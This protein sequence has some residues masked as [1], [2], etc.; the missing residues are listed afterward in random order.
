MS[1][2]SNSILTF[3]GGA[4]TGLILGFFFALGFFVTKSANSNGNTEI[5]ENK[6]LKLFDSPKQVINAKTFKVLQYCLTEAHWQHPT[7]SIQEKVCLNMERLYCF[8]Q[9]MIIPISMIK[10]LNFR[11]EN[12]LSRLEL[13]IISQRRTMIKPY[14]SLK[15]LTSDNPSLLPI[16]KWIFR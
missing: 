5:T 10:S 16:K 7:N 14:L 11:K 9:M 1:T 3:L 8:K 12:V 15:S 6:D 2:Q 4:A 13:I